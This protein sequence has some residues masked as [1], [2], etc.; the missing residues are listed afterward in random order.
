MGL[1]LSNLRRHLYFRF[2]HDIMAAMLSWCVGGQEQKYFSPLGTKPYI[3]VNSSE[4]FYCI[5]H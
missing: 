2:A 4:K 1:G 3:H 5:N